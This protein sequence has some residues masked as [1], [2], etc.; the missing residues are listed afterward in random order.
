MLSNVSPTRPNPKDDA[1]RSDRTKP[2][3][4]PRNDNFRKSMRQKSPPKEQDEHFSAVEDREEQPSLFDL[5]KSRKTKSKSSLNGKSSLK[6]E[7]TAD[8][9]PNRPVTAGRDQSRDQGQQQEDLS[10]IA[11]ET[12]NTS[13]DDI[14][15]GQPVDDQLF[16]ATEE[17]PVSTAEEGLFAPEKP[18]PTVAKGETKTV[19][20]PAPGSEMK[21]PVDLPQQ[22]LQP[23]TLEL[24]KQQQVAA[25]GK[26]VVK[27]S[28]EESSFETDKLGRPSKTKKN[29]KADETRSEKGAEAKGETAAAIHADIQAV[30]FQTEKAQETQETSRSATI[31][32]LAA[33][34]V[35][36]IQ[37]MR[38][39]NET[40]TT[41]T[42]RHPPVLEGATITLTTTDNAKREFNISFANL[43]ADAKLMLDRKLKE[44]PLTDSLERKGIVV[45]MLTTTT[46]PETRIA[47]DAGQ[48][49]RD[50]Q[51]QREQQQE[52]QQRRQNFQLTDEEEVT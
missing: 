44:D 10:M 49:F 22:P 37:V 40:H 38:R 45:H 18:Q 1:A 47:T 7:S 16:V 2:E 35:D 14:L 11:S 48:T 24:V 29:G 36:R 8:L 27:G 43:S 34:I 32:E 3:T 28:G 39:D 17:Q 46:E 13:S 25:N 31:R 50:R 4:P 5:S 6:E 9:R 23:Q 33:Q 41:I 51:G 42:L 30:G 52:Q 12:E 26:K 15:P 21:K 20:P 19:Q